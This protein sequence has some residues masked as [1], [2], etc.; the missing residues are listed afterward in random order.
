MSR[1]ASSNRGTQ[2]GDRVNQ[3]DVRIGKRLHL[4]RMRETVSLDLYNALNVNSIL[5]QNKHVR[6]RMAAPAADHAAAF[7]PR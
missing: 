2:F 5:A 6:E 7:L 1:S 3:V 4:A